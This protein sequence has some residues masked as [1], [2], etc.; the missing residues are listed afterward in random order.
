MQFINSSLEK[1]VKKLSD[2][3]FKYL[4]EEF[5]SK[6]SDLFKQKDTYPYECMGNFKRF[7]EEKLP[8]K[9][10]FYSSVKDGTTGDSGEKLDGHISDKDYL[11]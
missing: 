6:H 9:E 5:L 1:L 11:T 4:T 10:F 2:D 7:R 8:N 3:D